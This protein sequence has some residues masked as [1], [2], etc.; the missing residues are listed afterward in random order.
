M[1]GIFGTLY[2]YRGFI[3]SSVKREFQLGYQSSIL[4]PLWLVL[5]PLSLIL[6]YTLVFS[7]LM[8]SKVSMDN[9]EISYSVYLCSGII[10]WTLFCEVITKSTF[11]FLKNA[12]LIKKISFPKLCLPMIIA[13][14]GLLNFAIMLTIFLMVLLVSGDA[15]W[16]SMFLII[17]IVFLLL[18]FAIGL[19]I[20]L[21]VLNVFFRDV[22]QSVT[23]IL[24]FW[25]WLTPIVYPISIL[26]QTV[27]QIVAFNPLTG[28]VIASQQ[29]FMHGKLTG[30]STILPSVI[31]SILFISLGIY[32]FKKHGKEMVDEL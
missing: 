14:N 1:S 8:K 11:V 20:T 18:A 19:G 29:I 13:T 3:L 2:N 21:G 22:G 24:Q 31:S 6:V 26:P 27:Q 4:G 32:L 25:F 9:G 17:P 15:Y 5:Q 30:I 7:T 16:T 10:I 23:V 12:N 28:L